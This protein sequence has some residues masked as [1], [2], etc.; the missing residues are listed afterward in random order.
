M[1]NLYSTENTEE[2]IPK[3]PQ[4]ADDADCADSR[5]SAFHLG[6]LPNLRMAGALAFF[7]LRTSVFSVPSLICNRARFSAGI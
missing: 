2:T 6:H 4:F 3:L 5:I 1:G 7:V